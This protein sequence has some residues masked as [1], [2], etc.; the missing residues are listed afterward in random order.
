VLPTYSVKGSYPAQP[1]L[2]AV[3]AVA[4]S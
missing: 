1:Q 4:V 3:E 2:L